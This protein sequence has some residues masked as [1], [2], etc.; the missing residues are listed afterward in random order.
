M[1]YNSATFASRVL[2][3]FVFATRSLIKVF[4]AS[5]YSVRFFVKDATCLL[6]S[7]FSAFSVAICFR[8]ESISFKYFSIESFNS[9]DYVLIAEVAAAAAPAV[10]AATAGTE[11]ALE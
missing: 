8:N 10:E 7:D 3:V 5:S 6:N 9:V 1:S 11:F 2:I 4:F